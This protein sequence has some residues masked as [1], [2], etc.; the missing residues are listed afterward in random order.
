MTTVEVQIGMIK[1]S[2]FVASETLVRHKG[3]SP[4]SQ[5]I[6]SNCIVCDEQ[7]QIVQVS[8]Q[9]YQHQPDGS[10]E[11]CPCVTVID[12][13]K[14]YGKK[15][16]WNDSIVVEN[17]KSARV[18]SSSLI[19]SSIV[20]FLF[21]F[22]LLFLMVNN[23]SG[24]FLRTK[25]VIL[26]VSLAHC[27]FVHATCG[28]TAGILVRFIFSRRKPSFNCQI[29]IIVYSGIVLLLGV[30]SWIYHLMIMIK[31]SDRLEDFMVEEMYANGESSVY[32]TN[33][34]NFHECC[35]ITSFRSWN[36]VPKTSPETK[37][38]YP[39]SCCDKATYGNRCKSPPTMTE[40]YSRGCLKHE[41]NTFMLIGYLSFILSSVHLHFEFFSLL[42]IVKVYG[43]Q[44]F[45][46][47]HTECCRLLQ[48]SEVNGSVKQATGSQP[49]SKGQDVEKDPNANVIP[50]ESIVSIELRRA[51][52][53]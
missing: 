14:F 3:R 17:N 32:W 7:I 12:D 44:K 16:S 4:G 43:R 8:A 39:S 19:V 38:V 50:I 52:T 1:S 15:L 51:M 5:Q 48:G 24:H 35:G 25:G 21:S 20:L 31:F 40:V 49:T 37:N 41:V 45:V 9:N 11:Q 36:G 34:Q 53:V 47:D 29:W 26:N 10:L 2:S 13:R 22:C 27:I 33:S 46:F 30:V 23:F 6:N 18:F 28:L 42:S